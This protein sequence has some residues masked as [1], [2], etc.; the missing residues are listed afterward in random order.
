MSASRLLPAREPRKMPARS[1]RTAALLL[2][3]TS[4]A[5]LPA[6]FA[7][8]QS[9][10]PDP[11]QL[12]EALKEKSLRGAQTKEPQATDSERDKL[13]SEL[14]AKATRG[15]SVEERGRLSKIVA[16]KPAVDLEVYFSLDSSA[17]E[18]RARPT[19]DSLGKALQDAQFRGRTML[20]AG[21]TDAS[22]SRQHNQQLSERRANAVKAYLV[23]NFAIPA[24]ALMAVGY[25]PERLKKPNAPYDG[26]NR[27]V[28]VV[29]L[30]P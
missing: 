6:T 24:D 3:L 12:I 20:V 5:A 29:N 26:A 15:L 10:P 18:A 11:A 8:A 13:I 19:L 27:R 1:R 16:E 14:K 30:G 28:E 23:K 21:H 22:G 25:G 4:C 9:A 7:L 17:I 2:L